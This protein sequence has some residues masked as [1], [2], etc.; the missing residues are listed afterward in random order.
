MSLNLAS[1][2]DI[3]RQNVTIMTMSLLTPEDQKKIGTA[4]VIINDGPKTQNVYCNEYYLGVSDQK[5]LTLP[6]G[7]NDIRIENKMYKLFVLPYTQA[8]SYFKVEGSFMT[9]F[10]NQLQ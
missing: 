8:N 3:M 2:I 9:Q 1:L 4:Q 7:D 5:N 10:I 6:F